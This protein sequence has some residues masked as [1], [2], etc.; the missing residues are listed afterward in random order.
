MNEHLLEEFLEIIMMIQNIS[1]FSFF[2]PVT[3]YFLLSVI[4]L[5]ILALCELQGLPMINF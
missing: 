1:R 4:S 3:L 2:L 5:F